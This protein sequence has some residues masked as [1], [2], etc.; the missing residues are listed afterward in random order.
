MMMVPVQKFKVLYKLFK[1][2]LLLD[3]WV[4]RSIDGVCVSK[5]SVDSLFSVSTLGG[6]F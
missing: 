3:S 2:S 1:Q 5:T 6:L 4:Y